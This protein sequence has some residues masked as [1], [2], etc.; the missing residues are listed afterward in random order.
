MKAL[1]ILANVK[2][3][4]AEFIC[5]AKF[6]YQVFSFHINQ[7]THNKLVF[8][9]K[10]LHDAY[11]GYQQIY[12]SKKNRCELFTVNIDHMSKISRH[13]FKNYANEIGIT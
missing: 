1:F 4:L 7:L 9:S 11:V 2:E 8:V 10:K 12:L 3:L 6:F 13:K 5:N